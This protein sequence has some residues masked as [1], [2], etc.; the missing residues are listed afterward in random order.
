MAVF[1]GA[2]EVLALSHHLNNAISRGFNRPS[3]RQRSRS[4]YIYDFLGRIC[5]IFGANLLNF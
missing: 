4:V 5:G 1:K 3:T 2:K